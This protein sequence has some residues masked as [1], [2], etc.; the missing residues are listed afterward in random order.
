RSARSSPPAPRPTARRGCTPSCGSAAAC[1]SARSVARPMRQ[2][3][4]VSVRSKKRKGST[5]RA[6]QHPL[7]PDLVERD[8]AVDGPD[9][10]WVADF[11]Q[12]TTWQGTAYVAV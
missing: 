7:A 1:P 6:K 10:L 4:L 9:R 5:T 2:G 8:F 11:S 3:G 12:L